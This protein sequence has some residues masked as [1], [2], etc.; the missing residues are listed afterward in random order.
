MTS[1]SLVLY[2]DFI[3]V[4]LHK[5]SSSSLQSFIF[6]NVSSS[7]KETWDKSESYGEDYKIVKYLYIDIIIS[8]LKANFV[9][10][11]TGILWSSYD[12]NPFLKGEEIYPATID[13]YNILQNVWGGVGDA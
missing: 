13:K 12:N 1:Q 6:I 4:H 9:H 5:V 2:L 7:A 8:T 3:N 11:H 10:V